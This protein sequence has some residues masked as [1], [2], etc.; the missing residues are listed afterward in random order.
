MILYTGIKYP[1]MNG[2]NFFLELILLLYRR[3]T[4]Y[5]YTIVLMSFTLYSTNRSLSHALFFLK[6]YL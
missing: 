2:T 6:K 4:H 5:Y 1:T 3:Q